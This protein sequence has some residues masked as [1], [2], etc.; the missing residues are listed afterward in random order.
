MALIIYKR[1]ELRLVLIVLLLA[2]T[3][4]FISQKVKIASID[5]DFRERSYPTNDKNPLQ[6]RVDSTI[7]AGNN[8]YVIILDGY[9]SF[10]ILKDSFNYESR[11]KLYLDSNQFKALPTFTIYKSTPLSLLHIFSSRKIRGEPYP[12]FLETNRNFFAASLYNSAMVKNLKANNYKFSFFSSILNKQSW[13]APVSLYPKYSINDLDIFIYRH[14]TKKAKV[15]KY[16]YATIPVSVIRMNNLLS[17]S[18]SDSSKKMAV[19]HYYT[20]HNNT[21]PMIEETR[22]ADEVGIKAVGDILD[23]DPDA[24]II[25]MSDHGERRHITDKE[26]VHHG[27]F[28]VRRGY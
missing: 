23:K 12:E 20:F 8:I 14:L 9:P 26:L 1:S 24:T 18:L 15:Q 25:V 28:I 5:R 4:L 16:N 19:F 7:S 11:L 10:E 2:N 3:F 22:F 13:A 6:L 27:I 21:Q 17:R